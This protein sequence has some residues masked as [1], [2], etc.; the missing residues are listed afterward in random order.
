TD[1]VPFPPRCAPVSPLFRPCFAP[2]IMKL[3]SRHAGTD[4]N[5]FMINGGWGGP[6]GTHLLPLLCFSGGN[7]PLPEVLP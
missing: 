2:L 5:N 3:L 1:R 4:D 6:R 7:I